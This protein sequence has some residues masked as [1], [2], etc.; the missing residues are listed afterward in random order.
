MP[1]RTNTPDLAR[2]RRIARRT[3]QRGHFTVA[4]AARCGISRY[5]LVD[6]TAT[7]VLTRTSRGIYRFTVGAP[8]TW[9]DE[10]AGELLATRGIACGLSAPALY[11]L[12]SPPPTHDVLARRGSTHA[13]NPRHTTRTLPRGDHTIV[14]GLRALHPVR[15]IL[16]AAHRMRHQQAVAM[17]E[18]AIVRGLVNPMALERRARELRNSKRPGCKVV[19]TI[20][21]ELHPELERSR[22]EWEAL[23]VRRCKELGL[24]EQVL[25]YEIWIDGQ[26]Y[27]LDAAWPE[28]LVTLEFDGRDPH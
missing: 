27:F 22:N 7:G 15:A 3:S 6:W 13:T 2:L 1:T 21:A 5:Q 25:E 26:H 20:L 9:H 16:D 4:Q 12:I 8:Q 17:I 14:G 24:P 19:L 18:R 23:V 28:L 10:L 11:G